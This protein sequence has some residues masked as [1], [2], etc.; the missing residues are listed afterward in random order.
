MFEATVL[1]P[2]LGMGRY[3][4]VPLATASSMSTSRIVK[5]L[6][7][8]F[9]SATGIVRLTS[10]MCR[11]RSTPEIQIFC[12]V[13]RKSSPCRRAWVL[14]LI[15]LLPASG[16]VM[17]KQVSDRPAARAGSS[18]RFCSLGAVAGDGQRAERGGEQ[19][20]EGGGRAGAGGGERLGGHREFEQ[21][22]A[23]AA[24]LLGHGETEPAAVGELAPD[25]LG[26]AL[27]RVAAVPVVQPVARADR[28]DA[29]PY[30][31]GAFRQVEIHPNLLRYWCRPQ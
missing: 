18:A 26:P 16:S 15:A 4:S 28:R 29:V 23:S 12:P 2:S 19:I 11:A 13:T 5:P 24:V 22:L 21:T 30:G 25:L 6:S 8:G 27:V 10:T 7:R 3:V 31:D 1:V 17:A 20:E 9:A 14:M